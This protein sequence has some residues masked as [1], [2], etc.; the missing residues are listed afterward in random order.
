M[1][2]PG[3]HSARQED[4]SKY[5]RFRRENDALAP[6]VDVIWGITEDNKAE[7][8][9]IRF[10]SKKFTPE[11]AKKWLE[12]HKY[13]TVVEEATIPETKDSVIL[14]QENEPFISASTG[15]LKTV[16]KVRKYVKGSKTYDVTPELLNHW[17]TTFREMKA[18]GVKVPVQMGH[19]NGA[20]GVGW[21]E[22]LFI[23]EGVLVSHLSLAAGKETL[24]ESNDVSIFAP[25]EH[26]DGEGRTYKYPIQHIAFTPAPL[27]PGL[28]EFVQIAASRI[29]VF[30]E[31]DSPDPKILELEASLVSL[32]ASLEEKDG[33]IG[34]LEARLKKG[35]EKT[36]SLESHIKELKASM[37]RGP[38]TG[39]QAGIVLPN[40]II[41]SD[42]SGIVAACEKVS[43]NHQ[44][45]RY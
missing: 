8:Q 9:S 43:A 2:Y 37:V 34:S 23:D 19:E 41:N 17:S 36:V 25:V 38:R 16:A 35:D 31:E 44:K 32:K 13:K 3:E 42:V 6:G 30:G 10:D 12:D 18:N 22:N 20:E 1:P 21:V 45:G 28:G 39:T 40:P 26:K 27:F 4:P 5:K 29:P 14:V 15:F 33:K 24:V 11:E 7:V